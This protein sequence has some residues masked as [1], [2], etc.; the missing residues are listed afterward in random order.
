MG[1]DKDQKAGD[2]RGHDLR[3]ARAAHAGDLPKRAVT[4]YQSAREAVEAARALREEGDMPRA[5]RVALQVAADAPEYPAAA[6]LVIAVAAA[7]RGVD[8]QIEDFLGPYLE[9]EPR[10]LVDQ[11]AFFLLGQLYE[12]LDYSGMSQWLFNRLAKQN[13]L[14]PVHAYLRT[15]KKSAQSET[16]ETQASG[17][18]LRAVRQLLFNT[19]PRQSADSFEHGTAFASRYVLQNL[20][21]SGATAAVYEALDVLDGKRVALKI[22][23]FSDKDLLAT[24]RFRREATLAMRL[25]HPNIVRVYDVGQ[26]AGHS[27]LAMELIDGR[28]LDIAISDGLDDPSLTGKRDLLLQALAGLECAH[29]QGVVHRDIK[30]ENMLVSKQGTLKIADFGLAKGNGDDRITAS[31][32]M[33]GSPAYISPE[34]ITDIYRADGRSDLYSFGV[35]AYELLTGQLPFGATALTQLLVQHLNEEPKP[36]RSIDPAL[37]EALDQWVLRLLR[38]KPDDR[39]QSAREARAALIGRFCPFR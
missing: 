19:A 5:L 28:P 39:F 32:V 38:K 27:F 1:G 26:D 9:A 7:R 34:Q 3:A 18:D 37:P 25:I 12:V 4:L 16:V 22:S 15:N 23:S 20:L 10:E 17:G 29:A 6:R 31:G 36:L 14:H 21:G 11:D 8:Q 24:R 33:G 2:A 35:L 30:P 13:P